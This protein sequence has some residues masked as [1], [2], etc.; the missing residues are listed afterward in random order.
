MK[1][2]KSLLMVVSS[3]MV[4]GATMSLA[5]CGGTDDGGNT[6][7]GIL[8]ISTLVDDLAYEDDNKTIMFDNVELS[9]WSIIGDPDAIVFDKLVKEFNEEYLGLININ[10]KHVGHNDFYNTLDQ[11]WTNE[12]EA[13]PDIC[14]MHNEKTSQYA[15][16]GYLYPLTDELLTKTGSKIDFSNVYSNIDRVTKYQDT[17]FATPVD[18]HGFLTYFR[19]DI[20]KKNGLGFENNTR[21]IPQSYDEYY[22]LLSNL[23]TRQNAGTLLVRNINKNVD[24]SWKA[25]TSNFVPSFT[26]STDPDGLS[27]LYANGGTLMNE[28]QTQVSFQNNDGFKAYVTDMTKRWNQGLIGEK[29]VN[30]ALFGSG[31]IVMFSEGPWWASQTYDPVYNN[32]SLTTVGQYG[33]TQDDVDNYSTPFVA[34]HPQGWWTLNSNKSLPNAGKWYGNGHAISITRHCKS[35][36]QAAAAVEF[37]N[38]YTQGKDSTGNYHLPTWATGGHIPAWKN[39]YES[40]QYKTLESKNITLSALGNPE[41][42]MSMESL[43]YESTVFSGLASAVANVISALKS[44]GGCTETKALEIINESAASTQAAYDLLNIQ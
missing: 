44:D 30:T 26:Q 7:D 21:F 36:T 3:I 23:K 42:I 13:V 32:A 8:D 9:M 35:M 19:Q 22:S 24:H 14:F 11:T 20:I 5:S 12:P 41:D 6:N 40:S 18:A 4:L 15:S 37:M 34:D 10:V 33:I 38:W 27:A 16:K 39:V 17:R 31:D 29:G 28:D 1:N 25:A 43:K 2:K